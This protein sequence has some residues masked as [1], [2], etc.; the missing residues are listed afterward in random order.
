MEED[1]KIEASLVNIEVDLEGNIIE[2]PIN[3]KQDEEELQEEEL[4]EDIDTDDETGE[5]EEIQEEV[6]EEEEEEEEEVDPP[7]SIKDEDVESYLK[8]KYEI[9]SLKEL[10]AQKENDELEL[11]E[12]VKEF[13]QYQKETGRS[14]SDYVK[15][16]TSGDD[17]SLEQLAMRQLREDH[18]YLSDEEINYQF[19]RQFQSGEFDDEEEVLQKKMKLKEYA[20]RAKQKIDKEKEKYSAPLESSAISE[21]LPDDVKN[22]VKWRQ[23]YD[24]QMALRQENTQKQREVFLSETEKLFSSEFEGFEFDLG[25]DN[26]QVYKPDVKTLKEKNSALENVLSK[27]FDE[28]GMITD[29]AGYHKSMAVASNPEEFARFFYEQGKADQLSVSSGKKTNPSDIRQKHSKHK[30]ES[31]VKFEKYNPE[32]NQSATMKTKRK[33][34]ITF[35][36]YR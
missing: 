14:F 15:M 23:Q 13:M 16:K 5:N 22:A 1:K 8:E 2:T 30:G 19:K 6:D 11:P 25:E 29:V 9:S 10:L 34:K 24:E 4:N 21:N 20:H 12:V 36:H 26:K 18:P 7:F 33:P 28:N 31:G 35:K 17:L 27:F 32:T 3:N